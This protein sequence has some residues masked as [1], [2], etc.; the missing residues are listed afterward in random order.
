M[1]D[2]TDDRLAYR[3]LT[4]IDDRSF[5]VKVSEAIA[6]GYELHGSPSIVVRGDDVFAAQA[7]VLQG[8]KP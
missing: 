6:D 4:G 8:T 7:V 5:C 3:L 2:M 1:T